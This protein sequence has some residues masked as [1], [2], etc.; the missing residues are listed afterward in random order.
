[1]QC[2][3]RKYTTVVSRLEVWVKVILNYSVLKIL[4][5]FL[6]DIMTL[7]MKRDILSEEFTQ[8]YIAETA[9]AI[10][11]IHK[12]GFIH[13]SVHSFVK[14]TFQK[15]V[16]CYVVKTVMCLLTETCKIWNVHQQYF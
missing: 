3:E 6:G 1:M 5:F 8:F 10:D 4:F 15:V 7:L 9:L 13:R 11:S 2:G 12:L 16:H 14:K